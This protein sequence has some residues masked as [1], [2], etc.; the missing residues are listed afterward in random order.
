MKR[1]I[2]PFL[3]AMIFWVGMVAPAYAWNWPTPESYSLVSLGDSTAVGTRPEA[4]PIY[5]DSG[6]MYYEGGYFNLLEIYYFNDDAI[7]LAVDGKDSQDI[8][9]D[10]WLDYTTRSNVR[11]AKE[12]VILNVGGNDLLGRVM[13]AAYDY[14]LSIGMEPLD[15]EDLNDYNAKLEYFQELAVA[16][17]NNP[18][19]ELIDALNTIIEDANLIVGVL[20]FSLRYPS[21]VRTMRRLNG[22]VDFYVLTIFNPIPV[23]GDDGLEEIRVQLDNLLE[24]MNG[25]IERN[26]NRYDNVHLIDVH[27]AFLD[28]SDDEPVWFVPPDYLDPHPTEYGQLLIY[29]LLEP[30]FI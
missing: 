20:E 27:Q 8:L 30:N 11:N 12:A 23:T 17:D 6:E 18:D 7:S 4:E 19:V 5:P 16:I 25:V 14:A 3:M 13:D 10:L 15:E 9:R 21:I 1:K 29:E 26:A 24:I 22:D 2:I 28:Y